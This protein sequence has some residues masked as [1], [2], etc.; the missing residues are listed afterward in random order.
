MGSRL[1]SG[2]AALMQIDFKTRLSLWHLVCV[3]LILAVAAFICDWALA[4][5]VREQLDSAL[6]AL[7]KREIAAIQQA[8][9]ESLRIHEA[10]PGTAR[11][12]FER[13]DKFVQIV[14]S[15]GEA[16]ARSATLG[17]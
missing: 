6:L 14:T 3:A 5:L 13:L 9:A 7:A 15:D 17:T 4:R 8:P 11:P 2:A 1:P 10:P 12:S 16:L